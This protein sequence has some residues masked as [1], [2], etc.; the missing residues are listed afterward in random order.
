MIQTGRITQDRVETE[1][2][3]RRWDRNEKRARQLETL[4][5]ISIFIHR[6]ASSCKACREPSNTCHGCADRKATNLGS[7]REKACVY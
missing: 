7:E 6:I 3:G 5:S 4:I 1:Q 2:K